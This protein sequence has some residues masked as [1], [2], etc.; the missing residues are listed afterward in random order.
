M[1]QGKSRLIQ[2]VSVVV[3]ASLIVLAFLRGNF[4]LGGVTGILFA[5][6]TGATLWLFIR[7]FVREGR[8]SIARLI[9]TSLLTGYVAFAFAFPAKLNSDLQHLIDKQA[10]D[11]AARA[12]VSKVIKSDDT[13]GSL[14]VS[15]QQLKWV[16]VTV[17]GELPTRDA[18][19]HLRMRL[20]QE[21]PTLKTCSLAW[22]I[23]L[24]DSNEN[25]IGSDR[26]LFPSP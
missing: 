17:S 3:V 2:V 11:R 18:L 20:V 7:T 8:I 10:D 24:R 22:Q 26:E 4:L 12:E 21:C 15:T 16:L 19:I 14:T 6:V 1:T 13:F 5:L 9:A 23:L 25:V